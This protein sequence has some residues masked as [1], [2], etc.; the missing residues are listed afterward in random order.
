MSNTH[1]NFTFPPRLADLGFSMDVPVGFIEAEIPAGDTDFSDPT[2]SAPIAILS[3]PVALAVIAVA[4]R[5]AYQDGTVL[6]WIRYLAGHHQLDL[7]HVQVKPI[8]KGVG[9][10]GITAFGVQFQDG[11]KLNFMMAAFEDGGRLV[12]AHA[13]CPA[14]LWP[15]YGNAMSAA[16]ESITLTNPKG[17]T[18]SVDDFEVRQLAAQNNWSVAEAQLELSRLA[19]D[20][21]AEPGEAEVT[22]ATLPTNDPIQRAIRSART[23][24]EAD[25]FEDAER[26]IL[27]AD[28]TIQGNVKLMRLYEEH[29][30]ALVSM[31]TPDK[32]RL[33]RVFHRALSWAQSCYPE[34]HTQCE[35]D[36]YEAGRIEDRANLVAVLG[37][38][39]DALVKR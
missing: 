3:S 12:T 20:A 37:Y 7:Q 9:H 14:E 1:T 18:H 23:H 2:K 33:E 6:S 8:G 11:M 35:A 5:P 34:P 29:L 17:S 15:S 27:S 32:D 26:A 38:D 19:T 4:A 30:R 36:S 24:L 10:P 22:S 13:M 21:D 28:S 25:A 39:P 16:V 31:A